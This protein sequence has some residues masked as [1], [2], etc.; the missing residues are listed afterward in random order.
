ME[1]FGVGPAEL[2][3]VL[4]IAF[5][6]LGPKRLPQAARTLGTWM[7]QLRRLSNEAMGQLQAE[8]A[9]T[10]HEL[11]NVRREWQT[12]SGWL[13]TSLSKAAQDLYVDDQVVTAH[14]DSLSQAQPPAPPRQ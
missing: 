1:I 13:Q 7:R 14:E 3:L 2:V 5:V 4:I 10:T 8:L 6:V 12:T 11:D 9:D